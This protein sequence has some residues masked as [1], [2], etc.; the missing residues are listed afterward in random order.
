MATLSVNPTNVCQ[1]MS[2]GSLGSTGQGEE[3][4]LT[5]SGAW[6]DG[7]E[8]TVTLTDGLTGIATEIGA[9]FVTG[10]QVTFVTTYNDKVYALAGP[11]VF[12]SAVNLP[13]VFNDPN[14]VGNGFVTMS[15]FWNIQE[16]LNAVVPFQ[17]R[18]AFFSP[19][20]IQLWVVDPLISNWQQVQVL[21][22]IGTNAPLSVQGLGDFDTLFLNSSGFR[23]LRVL[24]TT[25]QGYIDDIGSPVDE[26]IQTTIASNGRAS[27]AGACGVVDPLTRRYWCFVPDTT[28]ANGVGTI[29]VLSLYRT[30]KITAW[31]T[32]DPSYIA[33]G[34]TTYFT[35][36][37]FGVYNGQVWVRDNSNNA[38][39]YGGTNGHTFDAT[40]MTVEIPFYDAKRPGDNKQLIAFDL[41]V[42]GVTAKWN[43]SVSTDWID[44]TF[45]QEAS[46]GQATF[47]QGWLECT[48]QGTHFSMQVTT[49][50]ASAATLASIIMYYRLLDNP[51]GAT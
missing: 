13:T 39:V 27:V 50:D 1:V 38:Y 20:S 49:T 51:G 3:Y 42:S 12:T 6:V 28:N 11:T 48:M 33:G 22:N 44:G 2:G 17:G 46:I 36:E 35:P 41:D 24:E 16:P 4:T 31:A 32:Y 9:G 40:Q 23:S 15:D 7:D 8:Y 10:Q 43:V 21:T 29:Y 30:S 47:D 37:I 18:L 25:L 34:I 5:V 26:L 45:T 19:Y 14:G